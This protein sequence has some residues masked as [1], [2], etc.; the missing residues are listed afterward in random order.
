MDPAKRFREYLLPLPQGEGWGEGVVR[1]CC[2]VCILC[3]CWV[4]GKFQ[5]S[6]GFSARQP[7]RGDESP[8]YETAPHEWG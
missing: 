5:F 3:R 7:S 6:L 8:R 2:D 4:Y 1:S